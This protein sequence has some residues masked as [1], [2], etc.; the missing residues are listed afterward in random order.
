MPNRSQ[1]SFS[2]PFQSGGTPVEE[3]SVAAAVA[4]ALD[5][6]VVDLTSALP[7]IIAGVVFLAIAAA[8]VWAVMRVVE[9]GLGRVFPAES[10]VYRDFLATLI[11]LFLWFGV[12]L[13]FLSVLGLDEIAASLGTAT[14]FV[15]LGVAYATSD[16]IEDAVSGVYL[17]RDPDFNVGDRVETAKASGVVTDIEL[18]KTR[19]DVDGDVVVV[20]NAAIEDNWRKLAGKPGGQPTE[21]DPTGGD[22]TGELDG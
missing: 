5:A 2:S 12:A 3:P 7:S 19:F 15:A 21:E 14:G 11:R 8:L 10:P 9:F 18:R 16:M 13:T 1:L 20:A 17:L 22:P 4:E 6:F